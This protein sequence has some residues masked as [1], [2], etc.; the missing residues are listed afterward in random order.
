MWIGR[1][2]K[3]VVCVWVCDEE[4]EAE[5]G[6]GEVEEGGGGGGGGGERGER[7]REAGN[8]TFLLTRN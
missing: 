4:E 5:E 8:I 6:E 1:L 3:W 7:D 2:R